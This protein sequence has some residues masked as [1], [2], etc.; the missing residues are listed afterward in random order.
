LNESCHASE[1]SS[2]FVNASR[3]TYAFVSHVTLVIG[4]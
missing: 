1:V 3:R 2:R 4:S